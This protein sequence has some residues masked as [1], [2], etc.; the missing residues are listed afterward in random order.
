MFVNKFRKSFTASRFHLTAVTWLTCLVASGNGFAESHE[1]PV[2]YRC[3]GYEAYTDITWKPAI[4][5]LGEKVISV[6]V[7]EK[8]IQ[9]SSPNN[10][11]QTVTGDS[12]LGIERPTARHFLI[13]SKFNQIVNMNP[14][15]GSIS[16]STLHSDWVA[17]FNGA[18]QTVGMN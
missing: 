12:T 18:C 3:V 16:I 15:W 1:Y 9:L 4:R 5:D 7:D 11:S 17:S 2:R 13:A 8:T 10:N 6:F 14:S